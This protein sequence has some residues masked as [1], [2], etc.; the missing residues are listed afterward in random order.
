MIVVAVIGVL[1]AVALP[2]Y[3]QARNAAAGG[4]AISEAVGIAKECSTWITTNGIGAAPE[5]VAGGPTIT[6]GVGAAG[7]VVSRSFASGASGLRCMN[8]TLANTV[9]QVTITIPSNAAMSCS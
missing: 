1:A 4:A 6:C 9:T 7:S 8:A 2:N 5:T 3:L